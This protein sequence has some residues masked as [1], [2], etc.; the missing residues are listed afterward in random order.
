MVLIVPAVVS[1][2]LATLATMDQLGL[3]HVAL[4]NLVSGTMWAT[5]MSTRRRMVGEVGGPAPHRAGD[6]A[7]SGDQRRH[8]HGR[9]AAGRHRLR[10]AW[11]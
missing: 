7:R 2:V 4:G 9:P 5:E 11:A 1:T 6:R 8:P 3:W 10:V